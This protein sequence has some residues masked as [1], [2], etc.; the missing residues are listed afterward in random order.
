MQQTLSIIKPDAV[1][2]NLIGAI[3][4]RFESA[5]FTIVASKMLHLNQEQAAGFYAEH[6]G[7]PFYDKLVEFMTSGPV[8]VSV[9]QG[10][11]VIKLHRE[12][13]G[14]TDPQTAIAGTL[15]FD[16]ATNKSINAVHGSDSEASAKREIE[17]FFSANEIFLR[18]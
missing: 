1:Q 10:E 5:R 16:Y 7:K 6:K 13:I 18:S 8:V 14:A 3:F 12:L 15:R 2:Q 9:L 4:S 11:N 17:Y